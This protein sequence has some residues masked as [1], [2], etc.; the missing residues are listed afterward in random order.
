ME[1]AEEGG[2]AEGDDD[3]ACGAVDPG[4]CFLAYFFAKEGDP[5]A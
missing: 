2:E 4:H 1:N 3:H 5:L